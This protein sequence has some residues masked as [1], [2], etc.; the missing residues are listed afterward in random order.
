MNAEYQSTE[1][2]Y[3]LTKLVAWVSTSEGGETGSGCLL[4]NVVF[5]LHFR[6][7]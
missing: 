3:Q 1:E 6:G 7:R 4:A 2:T 5:A